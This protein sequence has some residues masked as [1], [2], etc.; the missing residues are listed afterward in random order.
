MFAFQLIVFVDGK[1][2]HGDQQYFLSSAFLFNSLRECF[3][4]IA[5]VHFNNKN[6]TADQ[7]DINIDLDMLSDNFDKTKQ[8]Q[9]FSVDEVTRYFVINVAGKMRPVQFNSTNYTQELKV[10]A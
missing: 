7:F 10:K 9:L 1:N 4:Y 3:D 5:R 2:G 8:L 6:V